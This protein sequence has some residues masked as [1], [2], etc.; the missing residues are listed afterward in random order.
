MYGRNTKAKPSAVAITESIAVRVVCN[1]ATARREL[2]WVHARISTNPTGS[3][4]II[5][6]RHL[7]ALTPERKIESSG[8]KLAVSSRRLAAARPTED[9]GWVQT[10]GVEN[11]WWDTKR[12][13]EGMDWEKLKRKMVEYWGSASFIDVESSGWSVRALCLMQRAPNPGR[14][15]PHLRLLAFLISLKR[16]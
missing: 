15:T 3:R 1:S 8:F 9:S 2:S 12:P 5:A 10:R 14:Q 11:S 16:Y 7:R 4:G 13:T 6:A